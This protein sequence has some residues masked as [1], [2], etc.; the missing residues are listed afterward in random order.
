M[1]I[2]KL[3]VENVLNLRAVSISP[4]RRSVRFT[5]KN[6]AGKSNALNA[7]FYALAGRRARADELIRRGADRAK[8][9]LV[10]G[11]TE[12]EYTVVLRVTPK[13]E[14]LEVT[15][16]SGAVFPKP[17]ALLEKLIGRLSFDPHAFL[18]MSA[19]DRLKTLRGLVTLDVDIDALDAQNER[20][21]TERTQWNREVKR[22]TERATTLAAGVDVTMDVRP[23]DVSALMTEIETAS[24]EQR[25]IELERMR[26]L[27]NERTMRL[28]IDAAHGGGRPDRAADRA[29]AGARHG[30]CRAAGRAAP[31]S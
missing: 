14:T 9:R 19:A 11:E 15:A 22:L 20:D 29:V 12:A 7:I 2:L 30:D 25:K 18:R 3:E 17:Q 27:D 4:D 8:I 1:R 16:P 28:W 23:I 24:E 13:G 31:R 6:G 5:G 26:R 21:F 10:L